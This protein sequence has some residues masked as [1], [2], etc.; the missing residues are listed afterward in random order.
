MTLDEQNKSPREMFNERYPHNSN[1]QD[2]GKCYYC[3]EQLTK[4]YVIDIF[5]NKYCDTFCR[6]I[7]F[8][9]RDDRVKLRQ[10]D[11]NIHSP[12]FNPHY[13]NPKKEYYV[14]DR[15]VRLKKNG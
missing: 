6:N 14:N 9:E 4:D 12:R 7:S 15:K 11:F 10:K 5:G 1:K 8:K 3:F 13:F 2:F